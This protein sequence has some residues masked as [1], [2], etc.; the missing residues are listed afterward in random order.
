MRVVAVLC[1]CVCILTPPYS[2]FDCDHLCKARET[3]ICGDS[4]Q[5]YKEDIC[6]TQV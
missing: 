6:G 5:M 4:S 2:G 1:S 3:L